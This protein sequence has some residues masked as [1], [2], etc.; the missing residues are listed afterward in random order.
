M[1]QLPVKPNSHIYWLASHPSDPKR[2]VANSINGEV[3][4]SSDAGDSWEKV[5]TEFGEIRAIAWMPN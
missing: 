2:V 4:I 5:E 3:Y 1:V